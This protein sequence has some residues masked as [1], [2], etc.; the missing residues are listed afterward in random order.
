MILDNNVIIMW[1]L[2]SELTHYACNYF[3]L[4]SQTLQFFRSH[5][6]SRPP[7]SNLPNNQ[8]QTKAIKIPNNS[9]SPQMVMR[10]AIN[11]TFS[12]TVVPHQTIPST[13]RH[14]KAWPTTMH[15]GI[16]HHKAACWRRPVFHRCTIST[17]R[18]CRACP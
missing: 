12:K 6:S 9:I 17:S 18:C 10:R 3:Q 2:Y 4:H 11:S 1:L 5:C 16:R 15:P 13:S 8:I 14:H 7:I